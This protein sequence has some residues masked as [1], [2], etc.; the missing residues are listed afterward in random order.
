MLDILRKQAPETNWVPKRWVRDGKLWTS[1]ALLNGA[2]MMTNFIKHYW[3][4]EGTYAEFLSKLGAWT[5][6]DID[7]KDVA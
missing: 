1:G 6:R 7:Y 2:D 3:G 4:G 5:D